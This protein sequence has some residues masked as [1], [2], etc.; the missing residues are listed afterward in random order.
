MGAHE[1][2]GGDADPG[3]DVLAAVASE[4]TGLICE[5]VCGRVESVRGLT[6]SVSGFRVPIGSRCTVRT[7]HDGII[8]GE[9]VGLR[10]NETLLTVFSE[11]NGIAP[12][13]PVEC[14]SGPPRVPVGFDL[15]GRVI[16]SQ[17]DPIDGRPRPLLNLRYPLHRDGPAPLERRPVD[18]PLALGIRSI[19]GLLTAGRGQRL[20]IFAGTGV[21]KSVLLGMICRYTQADVNVVVLVGERGR[22]VRDFLD[23]DLG[24]EGL[25]RSVVVVC[26]S[27]EAAALRVRAC[28]HALAIAEYFRDAGL[29]VLLLMDSLTRVAMAQRQLGLAAG[30]PPTA[31]GYPPSVY[32]LLPRL[33]E[34]AGRTARGSI[35]GIYSV[36]VEGDDIDEPLADAVRGLLDGHIWLSRSLANRG[37]YPAVDV[38][39]SISRVADDVTDERQQRAAKRIRRVLAVWNDIEDLVSIGAYVPGANP[40][41]DVAV[42]TREAL[43]AFLTQDR[44]ESSTSEQSLAALLAVDDALEKAEQAAG[45]MRAAQT[46]SGGVPETAASA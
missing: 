2:A 14:R 23:K 15:L 44:A 3:A 34:R 28:L 9:V 16:N 13:D 24:E 7:R 30:E 36:L 20:G 22:E 32:A 17:G 4:V 42:N 5:G 25:A 18:T 35:T 41:Y 19:D 39:N 43:N 33:L 8:T 29:N 38:L 26:T 40:T 6:V 10:A 45:A 27:D 46:T 1:H 31:K 37:H 11:T 21:G 12:G